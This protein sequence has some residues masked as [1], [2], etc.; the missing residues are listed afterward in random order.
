[1]NTPRFTIWLRATAF[2]IFSMLILADFARA[3]GPSPTP[4]R[5]KS[6]A[7]PALQT[8]PSRAGGSSGMSQMPGAAMGSPQRQPP[9]PRF[10]N[11][12]LNNERQ[13]PRKPAIGGESSQKI[14]DSAAAKEPTSSPKRMRPAVARDA[15]NQSAEK[16]ESS[17][18][19][20]NRTAQP[21]EARPKS[22]TATSTPQPS[23]SPEATASGRTTKGSDSNSTDTAASGSGRSRAS[24]PAGK[25]PQK[26]LRPSTLTIS[27]RSGAQ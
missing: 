10:N 12:S 13:T 26:N 14:Q 4:D 25:T 17:G 5:R 16:G 3:Q 19:S 7:A 9:S 24:S 27:S 18:P 21:A 11:S 15:K 1:M 23:A 20:A 2:A 6:G 8:F 22:G